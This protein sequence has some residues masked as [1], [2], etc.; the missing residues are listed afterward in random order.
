MEYLT[1]KHFHMSMAALSG[2]F[3]FL[4]GL[5]M[6]GGSALL[7]RKWVRVAPHIVDSLLL[8]SAIGLAVWGQLYPG[9]QPWLTAK[10][11]GLVVYILLGT[12]ALKRG[13][14]MGVRAAAFAGSESSGTG[15]T[16]RS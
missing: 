1:L 14:T 15:C 3:F 10:I 9:Q 13:K 12:V 11:V 16:P 8:A 2:S 5:W 4:R 7:D 6:L